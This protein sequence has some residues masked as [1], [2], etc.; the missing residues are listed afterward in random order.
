MLDFVE[1]VWSGKH[2]ISLETRFSEFFLVR[3]AINVIVSAFEL[4]DENLVVTVTA[5]NEKHSLERH[6]GWGRLQV[7]ISFLAL[8]CS[9][10]TAS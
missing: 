3:I 10:N 6:E 2:K 1:Q 8:L 9:G 4:R 5:K 7:G